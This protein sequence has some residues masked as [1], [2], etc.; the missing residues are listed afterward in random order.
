VGRVALDP[1]RNPSM[2][3]I[4]VHLQPPWFHNRT[5]HAG[6]FRAH[7][8]QSP[9]DVRGKPSQSIVMVAEDLFDLGSKIKSN[10]SVNYRDYVWPAPR[11]DHSCMY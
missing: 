8:I 11:I 6:A 2:V 1:T 7:R 5:V 10:Y 9:L 4:F 3:K